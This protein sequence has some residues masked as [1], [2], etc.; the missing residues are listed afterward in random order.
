[1]ELRIKQ[2][3][4]NTWPLAGILIRGSAPEQWLLAMQ[5][6]SI[7]VQSATVFPVPG[8][9]AN[10]LWG[11]LVETNA[12]PDAARIGKNEYC[13]LV[14]HLLYI[15]EKSTVF[16]VLTSAEMDQLFLSKRH[17]FHPDFGWVELGEPVDWAALIAL[18]E[19]RAIAV[20]TPELPVFI[21]EKILGFQ[22]TPVS[23]EE[24]L[25]SMEK[26][27]TEQHKPLGDAPLNILEKA[28][29]K[30][31]KTLFSSGEG[32][33]TVLKNMDGLLD[34]FPSIN[35]EWIKNWQQDFADLEQRNQK[36]IDRLLDLFKNNPEEALKYAIPLD[37]GGNSRGPST[38]AELDWAKRWLNFDL[39]GSPPAN[40]NSGSGA[41][42]VADDDYQ[43]LHAQYYRS[44]QELM[45]K[46][47]YY[48]AAFIY[49]KLLKNYGLAA[50]ALEKGKYYK[51]AAAIYL[52]HANNKEKA[53]ACYE[54]GFMYHEAIELYK[55]LEN[56]E[57]V[58]DLYLLI[59]KRKEA[60]LHY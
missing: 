55:E 27:M 54:K 24:V 8:T 39:F 2:S 15:P 60:N 18:P 36:K 38:G 19:E 44:A 20:R 4:K 1:M 26:A 50:D 14:H 28:R 42:V 22:I 35:S 32:E 45:A 57:K 59:N 43:R 58:G 31:Y 9:T 53:A 25:K 46:A 11:C 7:P 52:K 29:L 21:P 48:K 37:E 23:R 41:A 10:S 33:G 17:V 6:M 56:H 51:E 30:F 3:D 34:K 5:Q 49:L 40:G 47:E 16:P 13:Q 12:V